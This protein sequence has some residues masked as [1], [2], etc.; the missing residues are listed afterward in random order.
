VEIH[1]WQQI[2]DVKLETW[3]LGAIRQ[4]DTLFLKSLA[5]SE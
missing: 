5:A 4:L 1:A 3:E 2:N